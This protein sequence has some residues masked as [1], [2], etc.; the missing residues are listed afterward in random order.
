MYGRGRH[1]RQPNRP[2]TRGI[3]R[4]LIATA[5]STGIALPLL[6][7]GSAHAAGPVDAAN[8][9]AHSQASQQKSKSGAGSDLYKVADGDTLSSIARSEKVEGGWRKLYDANRDVIGDDPGLIR[10]GEK[11]TLDTDDGGAKPQGGRSGEAKDAPEAKESKESKKGADASSASSKEYPNN[12]DGWIREALDIMHKHDIPGSYDGIKRNIMRESGGDP[13]IV[14]NWDS[15][16]AKGTPSKGLL[17][18]IQ[19]TF[20]QYHVEGTANDPTDPVANIVA[21][22]NYAAATYGSM[23]NVNGAY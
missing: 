3:S 12:L 11:L 19:P 18:V 8:K 6:G 17:Q 22:C 15:N 13:D 5:G 14:N 10:P 4:V 2:L 23:D 20:D 1:R 21:A 7:A 16:A 9:A